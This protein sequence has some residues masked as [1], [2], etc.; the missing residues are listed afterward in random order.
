MYCHLPMRERKVEKQQQVKDWHWG[1]VEE[2]TFVLLKY[3]LT[4]PSTSAFPNFDLPFE[5]HTDA[6]GKGL[7]TVVYQLQS[8]KQRVIAYA[9]ISLSKSEK[10]YSACKLEFLALKWSVTEQIRD[11]LLSNKFVL[12]T[13]NN[14]LTYI[15]TSAKLEA[16]GQ[17][18]VSVLSEFNF[19]IVYRPGSKNTDAD[20]MSRYAFE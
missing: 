2:H 10:N 18:W 6:S 5:L 17:K 16:T 7:G 20:I 12:F 9:S 19:D 4:S 8:G 13:D 1:E 15:L 14:T 3:L 11:Y